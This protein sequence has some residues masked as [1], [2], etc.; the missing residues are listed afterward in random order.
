MSAGTSE[1]FFVT[2]VFKSFPASERGDDQVEDADFT[3]QKRAFTDASG[4]LAI[5][6]KGHG[7]NRSLVR[8]TDGA[9]VVRHAV[10]HRH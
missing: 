10:T 2:F 3:E 9:G 8:R 4:A 5:S 1:L 7:N 6:L